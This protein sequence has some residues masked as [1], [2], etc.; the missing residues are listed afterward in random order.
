MENDF[1]EAA[2]GGPPPYASNHGSGRIPADIWT[3]ACDIV[4]SFRSIE[5]DDKLPVDADSMLRTLIAMS[6]LK[7]REGWGQRLS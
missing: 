5:D 1:D 4:T 7:E 2:F 6:L 3:A